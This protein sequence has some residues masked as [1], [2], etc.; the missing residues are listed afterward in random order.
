MK[1]ANKH[2]QTAYAYLSKMLVAG[3]NVDMLAVAKQELREA[4]ALIK[5][6]KEETDGR[7][8]S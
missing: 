1:D 5:P 3:D 2:I 8:K 7:Q 4:M 6:Q